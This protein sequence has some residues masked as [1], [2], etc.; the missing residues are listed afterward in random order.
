MMMMMMMIMITVKEKVKLSLCLITLY[1]M[2]MLVNEA[3][4]ARILD[5]PSSRK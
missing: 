4:A 2:K 1:A 3:I 5:V